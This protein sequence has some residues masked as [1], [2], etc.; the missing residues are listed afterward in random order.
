[1]SEQNASVEM[2]EY[3]AAHYVY[4]SLPQAFK[5]RLQEISE[6][7]LSAA[8]AEQIAPAKL[9]AGLSVMTASVVLSNCDVADSETI[10]SRLHFASTAAHVHVAI[11]RLEAGFG[12]QKPHNRA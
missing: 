3:L 6:E 10:D 7:L 5:D 4:R 9:L 2:N 12:L 1:M 8:E 11:M